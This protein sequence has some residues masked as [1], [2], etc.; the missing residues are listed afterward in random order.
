MFSQSYI[1]SSMVLFMFMKNNGSYKKMI[2]FTP[3]FSSGVDKPFSPY[4]IK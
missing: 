1:I 3:V 4:S 2:E